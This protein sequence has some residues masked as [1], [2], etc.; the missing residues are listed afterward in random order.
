MTWDYAKRN[1]SRVLLYLKKW[2]EHR[3]EKVVR[4]LPFKNNNKIY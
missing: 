3:L 2:L 1:N 4:N